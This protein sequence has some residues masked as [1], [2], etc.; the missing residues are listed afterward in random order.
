[1]WKSLIFAFFGTGLIAAFILVILREND[2][3]WIK[4]QK[5]FYTMEETSLKEELKHAAN[6]KESFRL[7]KALTE[8]PKPDKEIKQIFLKDLEVIDRCPTCHLG[9]ADPRWVNVRQPFTSHT[10]PVL[11]FHPADRFG[12][13]VCHQGQGL[14]T[15][16]GSAHGLDNNWKDPLLPL[17][18][19]EA[20]CQ[21]CHSNLTFREAPRL[22]R[23]IYLLGRL[24]CSGCHEAKGL[25]PD[26]KIGPSLNLIKYK[27]E[28]DW[29]SRFIKKPKA[30]SKETRM[31]DFKLTDEEIRQITDFLLTLSEGAGDKDSLE[32]SMVDTG[33]A[34]I[35]PEEL[36][37][38]KKL[39]KDGACTTCHTIRGMEEEGIFQPDKIGPELSKA[40]NKLKIAWLKSYLK[41]PSKH[42]PESKMPVYRFNDQEILEVAL[43]LANLK[44][45]DENLQPA[46]NQGLTPTDYGRNL[47]Q[48]EAGKKLV[49]KYNCVGCHEMKGIKKGERGP[50]WD[51]LASR[52]LRKFDFGN[53]PGKIEISRPAWIKEKIMKPRSFRDSLKM[54]LLDIAEEDALALTTALL[55]FTGRKIPQNYYVTDKEIVNFQFPLTGPVGNLW[56]ELK[57]LQCHPVPGKSANIGPEITYEGSRVQPD[58]LAK[59]FEKPELLRP[60]S[61]ARMPNFKLL[62]EEAKLLGDYVKMALVDNKLS[63]GLIREDQI[64]QQSLKLGKKLFTRKY[65]CISCHQVENKGGK[66]GP[67][68]SRLGKR[69]DGDWIYAYLKNPQLLIKG[70]M[71]PNYALTDEEARALTEYLLNL[72]DN[73]SP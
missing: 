32:E 68:V 16:T 42:Q 49:I 30:H 60:I 70:A 61:T 46:G 39:I 6:E 17:N 5:A 47:E 1:M 63:V 45:E 24:G 41:D 36:E 13:T 18:Y 66:V 15:T 27:V 71:M 2:R 53:N 38:G 65:G 73:E 59:Y 33:F 67:E 40:G 35:P 48:A 64:S 44:G 19:I 4:Y 14:A 43:F 72:T 52:P 58:W 12:C 26:D 31:P 21:Q 37:N 56:L 55:S 29:I 25:S 54:P 8:L 20:S 51:G 10:E 62:E 28:P 7:Q 9:L 57:C 22:T 3:E 69:L 34:S 23:G 50:A 11:S